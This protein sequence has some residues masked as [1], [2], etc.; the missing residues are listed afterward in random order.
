[1]LAAWRRYKQWKAEKVDLP[2]VLQHFHG[3][4]EK[5]ALDQDDM[6]LVPDILENVG[7]RD[8]A[9]GMAEQFYHK[10][11]SELEAAPIS[12]QAKDKLKIVAAFLIERRY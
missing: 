7:A 5:E 1:M 9:Q 12:P 4:I 2:Q 8:Y 10:A 3:E 6:T 11:L